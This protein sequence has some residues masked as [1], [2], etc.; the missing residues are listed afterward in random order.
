MLIFQFYPRSSCYCWTVKTTNFKHHQTKL[1]RKRDD[2]RLSVFWRSSNIFIGCTQI[3]RWIQVY[4]ITISSNCC[5]NTPIQQKEATTEEKTAFETLNIHKI[6]RKPVQPRNTYAATWSK[7]YIEKTY[8]KNSSLI[9]ITN[10]MHIK[11]QN[12]SSRKVGSKRIKLLNCLLVQQK[13]KKQKQNFLNT[14]S[15]RGLRS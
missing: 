3:G 10:W 2:F 7:H 9:L 15:T 4:S 1:W 6:W 8:L 5:I 13:T 11:L 14:K 12:K